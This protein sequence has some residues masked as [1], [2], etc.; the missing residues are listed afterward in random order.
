MEK[1]N[2][3]SFPDTAKI[4][5]KLKDFQRKTVKYAFK[6]MYERENPTRRFLI[7]DE[8]GLGKTLVARGLIA[9][10]IDRFKSQI[11]NGTLR[12]D[13]IYICSNTEIAKQNINRLNVIGGVERKEFTFT[14]RITLLPVE[15]KNLKKN[16]INFISFTPGTSFNLRSNEGIYQ[17]RALIYHLLKEK[18]NLSYRPKYVKFFQ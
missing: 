5:N 2:K 9:R 11:Q 17:E 3:V 4:L 14:S 13:I 15:L 18:W 7:A 1:E 16:R 6:Q 12:Y 8:V 10:A